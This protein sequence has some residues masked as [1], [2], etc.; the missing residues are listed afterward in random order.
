MC[1][2][3]SEVQATNSRKQAQTFLPGY[4][5]VSAGLGGWEYPARVTTQWLKRPLPHPQPRQTS[6][7]G[8]RARGAPCPGVHRFSLSL[9]MELLGR[10]PGRVPVSSPRT[11]ARRVG[12]RSVPAA[13]RHVRSPLLLTLKSLPTQADTEAW[14]LGRKVP[15]GLSPPGS[16]LAHLCGRAH[17]LV[18]AFPHAE[19]LWA[20]G[21]GPVPYAMMG[22]NGELQDLEGLGTPPW[23]SVSSALG[24]QQW[25]LCH[26]STLGKPVPRLR[27]ASR[28]TLSL[29]CAAPLM[30][31][32]PDLR[33]LADP[34]NP[35]GDPGGCRAGST[36]V[37][38]DPTRASH[39]GT[40]IT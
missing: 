31:I 17:W 14:G 18:T 11:A 9:S 27:L 8:G 7:L 26:V 20:P 32:P 4:S 6:S 25:P 21:H 22:S 5:E 12:G 24:A 36:S 33:T 30:P 40:H 10:A 13:G 16:G 2:W 1:A 38:T 28:E 35:S 19:P 3:S 29:Q 23:A 15:Q 34:P 39:V 37:C